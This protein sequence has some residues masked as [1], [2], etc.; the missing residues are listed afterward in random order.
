MKNYKALK[1]DSKVSVKKATVTFKEA[2]DAVKYI[3][4]D[5]IPSG[6]KVG[7]IKI[8]AQDAETKEVLQIVSKVYDPNTGEAKDDLEKTVDINMINSEITSFKAQISS[9]QSKQAD[10]EQLKK[11]LEAL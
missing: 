11:D 4:G 10:F 9:L 5:S 8:V 6:K 1:S 7:D 3:D 2:V